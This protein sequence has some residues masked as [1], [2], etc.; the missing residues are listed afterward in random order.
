M[1]ERVEDLGILA[2]K[3]GSLVDHE[4]FD[5]V[6]HDEKFCEIYKD[7]EK[8]DE[9]YFQLRYLKDELTECW[10]TARYGDE[11]SGRI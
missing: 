3:I 10:H 7:E 6:I 8:L 5:K 4:L 9:L 2:E 1:R 11:D